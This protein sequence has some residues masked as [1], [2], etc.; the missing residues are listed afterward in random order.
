VPTANV[1]E[2][3]ELEFLALPMAGVGQTIGAEEQRIAR[4]QLQEKLIVGRFR[5]KVR[6]DACDLK[7]LAIFATKEEGAGH[8]GA[9]NAHLQCGS[10]EGRIVNG[11]VAARNAAPQ[12]PV[13]HDGKG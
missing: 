4:L 3:I 11:G 12:Q 13:I 1:A 6:R 7:R 9:D 2:A 8:A 5:K 10:V